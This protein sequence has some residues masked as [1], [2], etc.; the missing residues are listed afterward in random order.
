MLFSNLAY[1]AGAV[2][3][4]PVK[5]YGG[6]SYFVMRDGGRCRFVKNNAYPDGAIPEAKFAV[7]R[8]NPG[9][10]MEFGKPL[11]SHYMDD[12]ERFHFLGNPDGYEEEILGMLQIVD[13]L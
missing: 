8:E 9:L 5:H 11:Y 6:M 13:S 10:G 1:A 4:A 7:V 3:Y 2:N 12:P